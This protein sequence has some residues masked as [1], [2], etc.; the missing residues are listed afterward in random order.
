MDEIETFTTHSGIS[1]VSEN[2][3]THRKLLAEDFQDK[4]RIVLNA[5]GA[6]FIQKG[7]DGMEIY[8]PVQDENGRPRKFETELLHAFIRRT[9]ELVS[10]ESIEDGSKYAAELMNELYKIASLFPDR[11][12]RYFEGYSIN[13]ALNTYPYQFE[14]GTIMTY[15]PDNTIESW[16][17]QKE[18]VILFAL[19]QAKQGKALPKT[20]REL[21]DMYTSS[22]K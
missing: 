21:Q 11:I 16:Q 4:A 10:R 8:K 18:S 14:N 19:D 3:S 13:T 22:K 1:R 6:D 9:S 15:Y 2:I 5:V 17:V 7:E 12:P 20:W